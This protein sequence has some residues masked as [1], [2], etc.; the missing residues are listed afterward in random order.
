LDNVI[1]TKQRLGEKL[2][3]VIKSFGI[4]GASTRTI[5]LLDGEDLRALAHLMNE[6]PDVLKEKALRCG[7]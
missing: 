6:Q 5:E 4:K 2:F 3:K 7:K 1:L